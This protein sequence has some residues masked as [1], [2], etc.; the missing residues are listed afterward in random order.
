M[1]LSMRLTG[2]LLRLTPK[3]PTSEHTLRASLQMRKGPAPIPRS[4]RR[5]MY[6]TEQLVAGHPVTTLTPR[7]GS[8]GTQVIYLHGGSYV[9]PLVSAHWRIVADIIDGTGATVTV[10][11][12][13]LAPEHTADEGYAFLESVLA[14]TSDRPLFLAGDSA[15]A[16]LA[17]G[18]AIRNRETR[19]APLAGLIL[20][21]PWVDV[22]MSNPAIQ[23]VAPSDPMLT[24]AG[25]L[26]AGTIWAGGRDLRDPLISPLYD[27]LDGLPP[28][29]IYQGAKD[30]FLPDAERFAAK[31][32]EAGADVS[33][34]VYRD[35]F[36]DFVGAGWTP[37]A[38]QAFR[39][40]AAII[41]AG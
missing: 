41:T 26:A 32:R 22:T 21:S 38:K 16:G 23:A 6:V 15:G 9:H 11:L 4:L 29:A 18:L 19:A 14:R 36:H 27:T 33:L 8:T 3:A 35:A 17:L 2:M 28:I 5:R 40:V 30:I 1:S 34:H 12:Y 13:G 24:P 37:E 20:F 31:A 7:T 25:Q 39:S 10:P